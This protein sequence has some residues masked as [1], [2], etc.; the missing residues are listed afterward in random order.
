MLPC[1]HAWRRACRRRSRPCC[2]GC[3]WLGPWRAAPPPRGSWAWSGT[4]PPS[5]GRPH[6]QPPPLPRTATGTRSSRSRPTSW[7][8]DHAHLAGRASA[9][10][11]YR[12]RRRRRCV[13]QDLKG[14]YVQ[15]GRGPNKVHGCT[16]V[17]M[18]IQP[19]AHKNIG[20]L[21]HVYIHLWLDQIRIQI[22]K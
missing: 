8:E 14:V 17:D 6:A 7:I 19:T 5:D 2:R 16:Y 13:V 20:I 10:R 9:H 18:Y 12:R 1:A 11:W 4:A 15:S 3:R 22:G 21:V